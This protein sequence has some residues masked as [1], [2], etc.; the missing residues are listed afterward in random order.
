M[1]CGIRAVPLRV[2]GCRVVAEALSGAVCP[3]SLFEASL[4]EASF[5]SPG[6]C[7]GL[8]VPEASSRPASSRPVFFSGALSGAVC[9]RSFFEASLLEASFFSPCIIYLCV[10]VYSPPTEV[11]AYFYVRSQP[12]AQCMTWLHS[13]REFSL[14]QG[15]GIARF[16]GLG[17][18]DDPVLGCSVPSKP[19]K[20]GASGAQ[21]PAPSV[22]PRLPS[23]SSLGTAS[24]MSVDKPTVLSRRWNVQH[25]VIEHGFGHVSR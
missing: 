13:K 14:F 18:P 25:I 4:L 11:G 15:S 10:F 21:Q 22:E 5:F 20:T 9:P 23:L 7:R 24:D 12:R 1:I 17:S 19:L 8:C 2:Y 6:L 3:R 16:G